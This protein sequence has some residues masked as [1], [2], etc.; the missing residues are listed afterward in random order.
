M[1]FAVAVILFAGLD[2]TAK[3]LSMVWPVAFL[4]WGRYLAHL[5]LMTIFLGPTWRARLL[6]SRRPV[7]HIVRGSMLVAVTVLM[8]AAFKRMPLAEA[9]SIVFASPL[10]VVLGARPILKE[11]IGA[12][13]WI[14]VLMG[15]I[16]VLMITRPGN[17]LDPIGTACA[18]TAA[19]AYAIYQ[20]MT[21]MMSATEH[22][23][24]MLYYTALTGT[25]ILSFALPTLDLPRSPHWSEVL[26]ITALGCLGGGG[27]FLLTR[28]FREAPAS[29]LAPLVYTQL[30]WA[31]LAGWLVFGNLPGLLATGGMA[32]ICAAGLL[33]A[34]E[35]NRTARIE[36]RT[37]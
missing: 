24:T 15:F 9:T 11:Q 1:L 29:L 22:P 8:M 19:I 13:Q 32:V 2:A 20:L 34:F 17:N 3:Y 33:I 25:V 28:A 23:V 14:A 26:A 35:G 21:R 12:L 10:L 5:L 16:G 18:L 37:V 30:P 7:T 4:A 27:H 6:L 36:K 31:T